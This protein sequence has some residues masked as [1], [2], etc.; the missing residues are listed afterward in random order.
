MA[1]IALAPHS[2]FQLPGGYQILAPA[3]DESL[4]LAP[5]GFNPQPGAIG[6]GGPG[7]VGHHGDGDQTG[8]R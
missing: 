2:G 5:L 8:G 3:A 4:F 1:P 7:A 6:G